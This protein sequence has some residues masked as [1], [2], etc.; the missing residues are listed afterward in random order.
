MTA[1]E[2]LLVLNDLEPVD[3]ASWVFCVITRT[4]EGAHSW[5]FQLGEVLVL[6][7]Q[8]GREPY[9]EGRKPAKWDVEEEHFT[10][11][12]EAQACREAVLAGTWT[13]P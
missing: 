6:N 3:T 11:L 13:K 9:G 10:T 1:D 4:G 5:P 2:I 8:F 12:G 7:E